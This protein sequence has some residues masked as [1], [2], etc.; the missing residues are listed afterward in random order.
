MI[1]VSI[2]LTCSSLL[3]RL[4]YPVI[5]N[6]FVYFPVRN[7]RNHRHHHHHHQSGG[8]GKEEKRERSEGVS[9]TVADGERMPQGWKLIEREGGDEIM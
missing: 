8:A 1:Q 2:I 4:N 6:G 3:Y 9:G 5:Y 7:Y